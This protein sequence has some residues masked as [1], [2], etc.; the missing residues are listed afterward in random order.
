MQTT[1][2]TNQTN[3]DGSQVTEISFGSTIKEPEIGHVT[4]YV[5]SGNEILIKKLEQAVKR[6]LNKHE[7]AH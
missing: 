6:E 7:K 5:E 2:I 1:Y 4:I 3:Q